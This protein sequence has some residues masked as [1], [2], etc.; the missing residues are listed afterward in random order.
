MYELE[1]VI[2][3][4]GIIVVATL[5]WKYGK[6]KEPIQLRHPKGVPKGK[7]GGKT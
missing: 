2:A 1:T 5:F 4:V 6:R 3:L 7:R